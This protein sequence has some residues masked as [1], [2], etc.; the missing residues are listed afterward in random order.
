MDP[1]RFLQTSYSLPVGFGA[2][3]FSIRETRTPGASVSGAA[4]AADAA[5]VETKDETENPIEAEDINLRVLDGACRALR[6]PA[7]L[8]AALKAGLEGIQVH[9]ELG[10]GGM[11]QVF[12]VELPRLYDSPVVLKLCRYDGKTTNVQ[13]GY[14]SQRH[15]GEVLGLRLKGSPYLLQTLGILVLNAR[16]Q[17]EFVIDPMD[18]KATDGVVLGVF[19]EYVEKTEDLLEMIM[20][21][22]VDT[23]EKAHHIATTVGLGL[24]HLHT[25]FDLAHRDIKPENVLVDTEFNTKI[26]DYGFLREL[27]R[28]TSEVGT[29]DYVAPEVIFSD[30]K[31]YDPMLADA[32]SFASLLF[33]TRFQSFWNPCSGAADLSI[34]LD[35]LLSYFKGNGKM[36][37]YIPKGE[38]PLNAKDGELF[39]LIEKLSLGNLEER[40]SVARAVEGHPFFREVTAPPE[41]EI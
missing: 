40:W 14:T 8:I 2:G 19:T 21:G 9:R 34:S 13:T 27:V 22:K 23:A 12:L 30:E 32:F 28:T 1:S 4:G 35:F 10:E 38:K 26:I 25:H 18:K 39:D 6:Y 37:D 24:Y 5:A 36:S 11:P 31:S 20:A 41:S 15:G 33:T 29:P 17:L 3:A 16:Q 7:G